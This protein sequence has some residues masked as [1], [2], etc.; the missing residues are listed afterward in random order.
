MNEEIISAYFDAGVFIDLYESV[1]GEK[2]WVRSCRL[3]K[4]AGFDSSI[5][6]CA[7]KKAA[8]VFVDEKHP[9]KCRQTVENLQTEA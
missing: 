4:N 8:S 6:L 2:D 1:R 3:F 5:A 9:A 7:A